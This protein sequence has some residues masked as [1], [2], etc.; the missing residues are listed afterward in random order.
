MKFVS[1]V[2]LILCLN[3][4]VKQESA[5]NC[6]HGISIVII[7]ELAASEEAFGTDCAIN[8]ENQ[9]FVGVNCSGEEYA[10]KF[11]Y[12]PKA[13]PFIQ[14]VHVQDCGDPSTYQVEEYDVVNS[15][16]MD[17]GTTAGERQVFV[18]WPKTMLDVAAL[19]YDNDDH[20]QYGFA[21][22]RSSIGAETELNP[23]VY[24]DPLYIVLSKNSQNEYVLNIDENRSVVQTQP[25]GLR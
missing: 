11:D 24:Y 3:A 20:I 14:T 4:C 7:N 5:D 18:G 16:R 10:D 15:W 13:A 1:L 25:V 8:T 12:Y 6:K 2:L 22:I 23:G 19:G 17:V 9:A 21:Y